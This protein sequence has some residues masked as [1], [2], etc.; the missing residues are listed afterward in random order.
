MF[1]NEMMKTKMGI[2]RVVFCLMVATG[3]C[4]CGG[5]GEEGRPISKSGTIGYYSVGQAGGSSSPWGDGSSSHRPAMTVKFTP[6]FYPVTIKSVTIYARNNTGSDQMFNL[7]GFSELSTETD[8][9]SPVLNQSIPDTGA[10]CFGKT[11]NMDAT[12]I[13]SGSFYM[14]VEWVTKPLSSDSGANSFFLCTDGHLDY[15]NT[16]FFRFTGTAW[17]SI[18]SISATSGD[19]G[20][21]VNY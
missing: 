8:I 2:M 11:I 7:Y 19:L 18:E 1:Q 15:T 4:A 12:A 20:I 5:G 21:L 9:F 6:T 13:S 3:L 10:S 14:A 17:S 16:S